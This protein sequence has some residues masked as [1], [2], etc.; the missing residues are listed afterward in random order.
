MQV[1]AQRKPQT[2]KKI[3]RTSARVTAETTA[4]AL[5]LFPSLLLT[6]FSF[7]FLSCLFAICRFVFRYL[8]LM[9]LGTQSTVNRSRNIDID[10]YIYT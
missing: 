10:I 9:L 1:S 4:G 3:K 7:F 2:K 8:F 6:E 5:F